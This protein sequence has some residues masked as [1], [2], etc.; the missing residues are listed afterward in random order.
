MIILTA[1]FTR[2]TYWTV[3]NEDPEVLRLSGN[4]GWAIVSPIL[5]PLLAIARHGSY[6]I[7]KV[8]L[9]KSLIY[10]NLMCFLLPSVSL[11][12]AQQQIGRV[13]FGD[14]KSE[15]PSDATLRLWEMTDSSSLS[16]FLINL[17]SASGQAALPTMHDI[18]TFRL[19]E[20]EELPAQ[21]SEIDDSPTEVWMR[22]YCYHT[23]VGFEHVVEADARACVPPIYNTLLLDAIEAVAEP[24]YRRAILYSAMTAEIVASTRLDEEL[25]VLKTKG[26]STG[27]LRLMPVHLRGGR[28]EVKDPVYDALSR[29]RQFKHLLHVLPLYVFGRSLL[30]DDC[31]LYEQALKLHGTRNDIVHLGQP[32]ENAKP[33]L[34]LDEAGALEAISC[35]MSVCEWFGEN[36]HYPIPDGAF[37]R[38]G[39]KPKDSHLCQMTPG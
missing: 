25:G 23:A 37:V 12:E 6:R 29:Q 21:V 34:T 9:G 22:A 7:H 36:Y 8:D 5:Y 24:D 19:D 17:R 27:R 11:V 3:T 15:H 28:T 26:D 30:V 35:A 31:R 10:S 32:S 39:D 38:L 14:D 2:G 16:R 33:R 18:S 20:I 1:T 4:L 13:L